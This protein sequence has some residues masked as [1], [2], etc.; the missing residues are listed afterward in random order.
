MIRVNRS[1]KGL[2]LE[3][4]SS[5]SGIFTFVNLFDE[6]KFGNDYLY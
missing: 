6:V 2:M 1:D 4:S 3:I 5:H